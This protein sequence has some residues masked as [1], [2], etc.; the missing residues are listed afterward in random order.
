MLKTVI[1]N[2]DKFDNDL[3]IIVVRAYIE[4]YQKALETLEGNSD[5]VIDAADEYFDKIQ[6]F[7]VI[8]LE[9]DDDIR[10]II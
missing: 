8:K 2:L 6:D 1:K 10:P 7:R 9:L 5:I 3:K 4:G